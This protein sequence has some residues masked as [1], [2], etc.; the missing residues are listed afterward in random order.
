M[1]AI[2]A[3]ARPQTVFSR[4][5]HSVDVIAIQMVVD[6]SGSM[7]ALDMSIRTPAG[8]K[9]RTRLDAVK[10]TFARFVEE[11][12]DDLIGLVTFGGYATTRCPLTTDHS[13]LLHVLKGVQ[14]PK[15]AQDKDGR[16]INQEELLTAI[17]DALATACARMEHAEPKSKIIVLLSDGE[18]NTGIIKPGE[19]LEAAK[20]LDIKAYTIG[21]G[22]S[23]R[24]P[25][26]GRD[27]FGRETI[28]YAHV[29]LDEKLLRKIAD[30]TGGQYFNVRDPNGLKRAMDDINALEKTRVERDVYNQYNELFLWFL[31]P[32][33]G[34]I[35]LATSFNMLVTRKIV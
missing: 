11:R 13:A 6:V 8:V 28:Q 19:A 10:E 7:E 12:P 26:R 22:S 16:V 29:S 2:I 24:A 27:I 31:A 20:K 33:V 21:V 18:S 17:G 3:L 4:T 23:D 34:L 25:F 14:I 1:L 9:Y 15:P 30:R 35:V 32:A 5:R